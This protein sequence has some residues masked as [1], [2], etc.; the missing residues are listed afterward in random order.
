MSQGD[1]RERF[2]LT[3]LHASRLL[4]TKVNNVPW[5]DLLASLEGRLFWSW[6]MAIAVLCAF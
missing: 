5:Q 1:L 3:A 4:T 2:R 6:Q